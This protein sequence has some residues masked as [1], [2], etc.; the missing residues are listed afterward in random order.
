ME[1][2]IAILGILLLILLGYLFLVWPRVFGKPERAAFYGVHY[3]HRGL[4]DNETEAPENSL[5]AIRNAVNSGHG[6]EFDVQLS[7]D[8]VPVVFHDASLKRMCGVK[9]KIWEYTLEEL[10]GMRLANSNQTIPTLREVLKEVNGKVPLIIEYKMD[11]VDEEICKLG[12]ELLEKYK[13]PYCVESFHPLALRWYRKHRPDI[14]RGQ[15][16]QKF[17]YY[18]KKDFTTWILA[19][20]FTNV[21]TRPDFI[22]YRYTDANSFS[23]RVCGKLGALSVAWTIRSQGEFEKFQ[24]EFDLFIFDSFV[25]E[26]PKKK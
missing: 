23:R 9:G 1:I 16:S 26:N 10:Q 6:I 13:G 2:I 5:N 20:L 24:K 21:W 8:H 7:K 19:N 17:S 4:F 11:R 22:A 18:S 25:L 3:A 15:L 12:N 14:M